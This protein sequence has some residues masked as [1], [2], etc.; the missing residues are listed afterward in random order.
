M[1]LI[2]LHNPGSGD[3][4][5]SRERLESLLEGAGHEVLYHS[6]K[7][8]GWKD[9][10]S[11]SGDVIVVAGGD[12][13]VRKVFTALRASS[14]MATLFPVGSANNIARTLGFETDDPAQLLAGWEPA[15]RRP[16]DLWEADVGSG[17]TRFVE[18]FGGGLFGD[19]LASAEDVEEG[20]T[21]DEK[22]DTGLQLVRDAIARATP[23]AW[24]LTLDGKH[25]REELL[26]VEAMNIQRLGPGLP[27]APDA[28]PGD[29]LLEVVLLREEDRPAL[30]AYVDARLHEDAA[31]MPRLTVLSARRLV[32]SVPAGAHLHLD[33]KLLADDADRPR[34]AEVRL[35]GV[36]VDV[37]VPAA[38]S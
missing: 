19:V 3:E 6:L 35:A 13:S 10:L 32:L 27:L 37:L 23:L 16:Y 28:D 11:E 14:T 30:E 7:A 9:V 29:G 17:P 22:V 12:G 2:L 26:G 36:T 24:E 34:Q 20:E 18:S 38:A 31:P 1:R 33:D 5:H 21:A 8:K 15:V 4:D 25:R